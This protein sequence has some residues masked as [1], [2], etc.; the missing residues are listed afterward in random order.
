[1]ARRHRLSTHLI[2][3]MARSAQ[4][5]Y[6]NLQEEATR[7]GPA[8]EYARRACADLGIGLTQKIE[9]EKATVERANWRVMA[10]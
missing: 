7:E 6:E 2:R 4:R 3:P 10:E 8:G 1:M 9:V 5:E